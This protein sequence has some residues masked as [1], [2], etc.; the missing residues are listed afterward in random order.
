M[1]IIREHFLWPRSVHTVEWPDIVAT[2]SNHELMIAIRAG[3]DMSVLLSASDARRIAQ[4]MLAT[5]R[6]DDFHKGQR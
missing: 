5:Y 2:V 4:V 3:W 1:K 6:V